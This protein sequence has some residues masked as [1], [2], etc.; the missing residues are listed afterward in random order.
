MRSG[1]RHKGAVVWGAMALMVTTRLWLGG[2]V[3]AQRDR[4]LIERLV[5]LVAPAATVGPLLFVSDG[6]TSYVQAVRRAFRTPQSGTR[7]RPRLVAWPEL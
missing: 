4:A 3:S 5:A 7:G 1:S 2:V 6:L